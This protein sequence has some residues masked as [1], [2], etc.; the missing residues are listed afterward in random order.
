MKKKSPTTLGQ[1][2]VPI[3]L[4]CH[5]CDR[6]LPKR[7]PIEINTPYIVAQCPSCGCLTPFKGEGAA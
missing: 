5:H 7:T 6:R 3:P 1:F 4:R 2:D